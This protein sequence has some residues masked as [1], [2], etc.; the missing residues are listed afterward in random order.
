MCRSFLFMILLVAIAACSE[1][2]ESPAACTMHDLK[3]V[4]AEQWKRLSERTVYFG[5]QSVGA[6]IVEGIREIEAANPQIRLRVSSDERT[7]APGVLN[8]FYIG[9]NE[10]PRFEE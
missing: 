4:S 1:Q 5:H 8:E 9:R 7:A 6:N 3:T 2:A 10:N